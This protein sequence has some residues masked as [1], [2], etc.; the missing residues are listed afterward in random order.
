MRVILGHEIMKPAVDFLLF[1]LYDFI[2]YR[3][4][5]HYRRATGGMT[6]HFRGKCLPCQNVKCFVPNETKRNKIQPKLVV[7]GFCES[8]T[9]EDE[10]AVIK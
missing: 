1:F 7:Q 5:Y 3:F 2:M 8:V 9:I 10:V 4:F 6:V